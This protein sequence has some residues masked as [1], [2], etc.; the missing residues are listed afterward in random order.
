MKN[1]ICMLTL[2]SVLFG[3]GCAMKPEYIH[4]SFD[5]TKIDRIVV[6]PFIDNRVN[7]NPKYDFR[8]LCA[9]ANVSIIS[10]LK[11][12]K[13]YRVACTSDLG[14]VSNYSRENLATKVNDTRNRYTIDPSSVNPQWAKDLGP[15]SEE[16][17]LVPVLEAVSDFNALIVQ[18]G[19]AA[20]SVYLFNRKTGELY[21]KDTG[22]GG[23]QS[24]LL[25]SIF[26][27]NNGAKNF[28]AQFSIDIAA[29]DC[30]SRFPKREKPR[31]LSE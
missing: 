5:P 10:E 19:S 12:N 22:Y 3:A 20:I 2:L 17:I 26:A 1:R 4:G 29:G 18:Q 16:W 27:S 25:A 11:Y 8:A 7:P 23:L 15:S 6:L 9:E 31:Y 24:G 30:V 21:L 13:G 14:S 28:H